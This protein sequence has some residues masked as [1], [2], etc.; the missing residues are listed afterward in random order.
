MRRLRHLALRFFESLR[1]KPLTP[2]EQQW[3]EDRLPA[4]LARLFWRQH[5]LDQRHA[6]EVASRVTDAA[7]ARPD[8]VEA[9]L[10]HDVGK[11]ESHLGVVLRVVATT[12][13]MFR[14]PVRGR[15]RRYVEHGAIGAAMLDEAGADELAVAF[16][17]GHHGDCPVG[18]DPE[19]WAILRAADGE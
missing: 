19:A 8:L 4:P 7:P 10:T 14:V 11:S 2:A 15:F 3:V 9:A 6:F 1:S 13:S 12:L 16:A 18:T 17:L 5:P